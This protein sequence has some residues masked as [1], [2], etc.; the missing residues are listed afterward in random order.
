[1]KASPTNG[2]D[3]SLS[4]LI[5][6]FSPLLLGGRKEEREE[7]Q[8]TWKEERRVKKIRRYERVKEGGGEDDGE[9]VPHLS[10]SMA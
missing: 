8:K 10:L 6:I 7:V 2:V 9:S 3:L 4:G 1:M 5:W